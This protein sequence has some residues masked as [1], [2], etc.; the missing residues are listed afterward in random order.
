[1][2]RTQSSVLHLQMGQEVIYLLLVVS[3]FCN[4]LLFVFAARTSN[5]VTELETMKSS[6]DP[7]KLIANIKQL[8]RDLEA[9]RRQASAVQKQL[10]EAQER[11]KVSGVHDRPPIIT[12]R[13]ADGF[14]FAPG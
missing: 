1:M 2:N 14:S 12:L 11:L 7:S 6:G 9:A 4:V 13:E 3:I 5:R 8:E 10:R